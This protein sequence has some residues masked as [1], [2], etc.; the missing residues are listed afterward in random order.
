MALDPRHERA[1]RP[2]SGAIA[3]ARTEAPPGA[4]AGWFVAGLAALGCG[5]PA[6]GGSRLLLSLLAMAT[7]ILGGVAQAQKPEIPRIGV[8]LVG[9]Y[10]TEG[11]EI[12]GFR[13]GLREAGYVDG[14]NVAIEWRFANGDYSRAPELAADLVRSNV[15]VIVVDVTVAARA[16]AQATSTIPIVMATVADPIGSGLVTDLAHPGGNITGVNLMYRDLVGKR[17]EML[18]ELV[19]RATRV[20]VVWNPATPYHTKALQDVHAAARALSIIPA[21]VPVNN[22]QE[23]AGVAA[24]VKRT[25]AEAIFVVDAPMFYGQRRELIS[26]AMAARIPIAFADRMFVE[27]GALVS[28][29]P[30]FGEMFNKAAKYAGKILKGANAGDLP[31]E[32]PTQFELVVN[33]K[34]AKALGI[35]IPESILLR[36]DEVIR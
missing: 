24:A 36:A 19:P 6:H 29:G 26:I 34:T 21:L 3:S 13:K 15:S 11:R 27:A 33:L 12:A 9:G 10:E 30:N 7:F 18:K 28:Y 32:Q 35:T 22:A 23:L 8:L 4:R 25:N 2:A 5:Q 16:A 20:V 14:T 31:I 17:V 1:H